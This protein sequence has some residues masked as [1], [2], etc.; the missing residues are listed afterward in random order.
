MIHNRRDF[1]RQTCYA[2]IGLAGI[3]IIPASAFSQ[4]KKKNNKESVEN[5]VAALE[6]GTQISI[7]FWRVE[8]GRDGPSLLLIAAQHGNE[9]QGTEVARRFREVCANQLNTGSVWLIPMANLQAIHRGRHSINLGPEDPITKAQVEGYNMNLIWPGKPDGNDTQRL[10]WALDQSVLRHCSHSVDIHCWE[11]FYAAET[12][13][14]KV[15]EP[16]RPLGEVT[17]T[18]FIRYNNEPYFKDE[19][20]VL[21]S[22]LIR[23]RGGGAIEI[24]L[25]G[26]YQI[27]EKQVKTGLSSMINIAKTLGMIDGVPELIEGPR[28]TLSQET[29]HE[30]KAPCSGIFVPALRKDQS[31]SLVPEDYVEKGQ[32][33]GHIIRE[34]DL[35]TV[36]VTATV[37]GYLWQLGLCHNKM[38][39]VSLPAQNPYT[40][41][42][43]TLALIVTV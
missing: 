15:H 5:A 22:H 8:S 43:E 10:A 39:D 3:T 17:T 31:G 9:V 12:L 41:E 40:E 29:R 23:R 13:A 1:I 36:P 34:K 35:A 24:E 37:S 30:I 20:L 18:R 7:P 27:R 42:G 19:K 11:H 21:A 25:S 14:V 28:A 32:P 4:E 33:L 16:T 38:C 26:Q 2:G 6:D